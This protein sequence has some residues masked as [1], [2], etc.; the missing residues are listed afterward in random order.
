MSVR[1]VCER[2]V[3]LAQQ[4]P[5]I[6]ARERRIDV[7]NRD[8]LGLGQRVRERCQDGLGEVVIKGESR[9]GTRRSSSALGQV[10]VELVLELERLLDLGRR[11]VGVKTVDSRHTEAVGSEGRERA[12]LETRMHHMRGSAQLPGN[13]SKVHAWRD[14]IGTTGTF[15]RRERLARFTPPEIRVNTVSW[16]A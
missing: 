2:T 15:A 13:N 14:E 3:Q 12:C 7:A 4:F 8:E 6:E 11:D 9:R 10:V 1:P 5:I 16:P